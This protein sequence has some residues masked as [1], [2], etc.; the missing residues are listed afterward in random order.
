MTQ[1]TY[2]LVT[3]RADMGEIAGFELHDSQGNCHVL[4]SWRTTVVTEPI[5]EILLN[6]QPRRSLARNTPLDLDEHLGVHILLVLRAVKPLSDY[7]RT[8]RVAQGIARMSREEATYWHAH[9]THKGGLPALR[10]LLAP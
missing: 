1:S 7:H 6:A 5:A 8:C 4:N 3:H 9:A 2:R 10:R